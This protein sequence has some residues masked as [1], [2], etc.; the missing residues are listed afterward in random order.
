MQYCYYRTHSPLDQMSTK[1]DNI[2]SSEHK[3][4]IS[5]ITLLLP[6]FYNDT[7][8]STVCD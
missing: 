1:P 4:I 5:V 7:L 2:E 8:F 3:I 6:M